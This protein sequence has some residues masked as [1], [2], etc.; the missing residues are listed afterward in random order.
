MSVIISVFAIA[1]YRKALKLVLPYTQVNT[2]MASVTGA[3]ISLIFIL[4]VSKFYEYI[5]IKMTDWEHHKTDTD[6]ENA[7]TVKVWVFQFA[8]FYGTIIYIAFAKGK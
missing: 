1:I 5:A 8:N 7:L 6:Y 3:F 2:Y 4:I